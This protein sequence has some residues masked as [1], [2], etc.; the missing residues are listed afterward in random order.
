M[1]FNV[2][3]VLRA[4]V[5]R[6]IARNGLQF[7]GIFFLL[8]VI[9]A[10]V[11]TATAQRAIQATDGPPG[12]T[13][14]PLPPISPVIGGIVSFLIAIASVIVL[15]AAIRTFV[16]PITETI[17]REHFTRRIA[18]TWINFVIGTIVFSVI[19]AIGLILLIVPGLFILVSLFFWSVFVAERSENFIDAFQSSWD[20]TKGRRLQLFLLGIIVVGIGIVIG[21]VFSA[22]SVILPGF[23]GLLVQAIGSAILSV[24]YIATLATAYTHLVDTSQPG[25]GSPSPPTASTSEF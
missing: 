17:P 15:I 3:D 24:F 20:L 18:W 22:F 11:V 13:P 8:N 16:S 21:G 12:I 25:A 1:S 19:V 14:S 5:E 7:A 10:A 6:T 23:L 4:G 9:N 2:G